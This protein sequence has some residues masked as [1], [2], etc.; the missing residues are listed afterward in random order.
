M[1]VKA[2]VAGSNHGERPLNPSALRGCENAPVHAISCNKA[3]GDTDIAGEA[4]KRARTSST[5]YWLP[6]SAL[7]LE[8]KAQL[9]KM[10]WAYLCMQWLISDSALVAHQAHQI[11][12]HPGLPGSGLHFGGLHTGLSTHPGSSSWCSGYPPLSQLFRSPQQQLLWHSGLSPLCPLQ[13]KKCL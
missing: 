8:V 2:A 9:S 13:R 5:R 12:W 6:P 10:L 4:K 1:Q 7:D 3:T 11:S